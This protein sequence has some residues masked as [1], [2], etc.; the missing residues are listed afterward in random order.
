MQ[1]IYK[2]CQFQDVISQIT[3]PI[4]EPIV[5]SLALEEPFTTLVILTTCA[6]S[7]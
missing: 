5:P 1:Q 3:L 2:I 7:S 6:S 4:K